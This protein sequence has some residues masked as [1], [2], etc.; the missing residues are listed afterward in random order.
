MSAATVCGPQHCRQSVAGVVG[1]RDCLFLVVEWSDVHTGTENL[2][3]DWAILIVE[4]GPN[5]RR[6]PRSFF[7]AAPGVEDA[8][9]RYDLGAGFGGK[10]VVAQDFIAMLHRDER[11]KRRCLVER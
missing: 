10:I 4:A 7:K 5:G 1:T 9:A 2:L 3:P 11:S 8:A 6:D